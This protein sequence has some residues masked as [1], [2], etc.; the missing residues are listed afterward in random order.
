MAM[1]SERRKGCYNLWCLANTW[2]TT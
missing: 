1:F 2:N